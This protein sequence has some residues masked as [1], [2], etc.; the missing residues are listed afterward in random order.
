[1]RN[2]AIILQN[3]YD[4]DRIEYGQIIKESLIPNGNDNITD[5]VWNLY[6]SQK[7]PDENLNKD[8]ATI[9]RGEF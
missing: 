4:N 5:E 1:M 8:V 2:T 7:V 9:Q 3:E 6:N